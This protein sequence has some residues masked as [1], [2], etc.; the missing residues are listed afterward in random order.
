[1][2]MGVYNCKG[3]LLGGGHHKNEGR[4]SVECRGQTVSQYVDR[5]EICTPHLLIRF[6]R[7]LQAVGKENTAKPIRG[8]H[9][10]DVRARVKCCETVGDSLFTI[11][12]IIEGLARR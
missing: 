2:A 12:P 11:N 9:G 6:G 10:S 4:L 7:N 5:F 3:V 1:M 8:T